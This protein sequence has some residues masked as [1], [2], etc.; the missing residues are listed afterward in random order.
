VAREA[1]VQTR[2]AVQGMREGGT[3]H[4]DAGAPP[5]L[6]DLDT[7]LEALQASGVDVRLEERP[8]ERALAPEIE[9]AAFRIVQE[10]LTNVAR[11]ARPARAVV[12]IRVRGGDAFIE[13][14]DAGAGRSDA[15]GRGSGILGMRERAGLVGGHL[16]AGP[17]LGGDGWHVRA[18]LPAGLTSR[19]TA[20]P[21]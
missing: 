2:A 17:N 20:V 9:A 3:H 4:G 14:L 15:I 1:L 16:D 21:G 13:V 19:S 5:R 18:V 12:S 7:L 6:A 11:H 10:A 8:P